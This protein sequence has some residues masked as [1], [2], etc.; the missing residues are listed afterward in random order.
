MKICH[1]FLL[2]FSLFFSSLFA[3]EVLWNGNLTSVRHT[4]GKHSPQFTV[5]NGTLNIKASMDIPAGKHEYFAFSIDVPAFSLQEK[6][7]SFNFA[8]RN[9]DSRDM[10][11]IKAM[12]SSGKVVGSFYFR[13]NSPVSRAFVCTAGRDA[14]GVTWFAS[15]VKAPLTDP[16]VKLAFFYCRHDG[17][18]TLDLSLSEV[19]TIPPPPETLWNGQASSVRSSTPKYSPQISADGNMINIK[20]AFDTQKSEYFVFDVDVTDFIMQGKALSFQFSCRQPLRGDMFYIK[21]LNASGQVVASF[22]TRLT[23]DR[24]RTYICSPESNSGGVTWFASDIKAPLTDKV[25]KLRFFYCRMAGK[26]DLEIN[27]GN[28]EL[29][30]PAPPVATVTPQDHGRAV[31]GGTC[32]GLHTARDADG[33]DC[34][35]VFLMDDI[36]RRMLQIDAATGESEEIPI[37]FAPRDAVYSSLKSRNG[38][39]YSLFAH[40]FVEY[41]PAQK[42][43]TFVRKVKDLTAMSMAEDANGIIYA[44]TYPDLCLYSYDP[45][46]G[47]FRDFGQIHQETFPQYPRTITFA[48]D[49]TLY[50]GTGNTR[51]Q[52]IHVYPSSGRAVPVIPK[53]EEPA[54][55]SLFVRRFTDGKIYARHNDL[56]FLIDGDTATRLDHVPDARFITSPLT[57]SQ[58]LVIR[59]F[60]S[61]RKLVTFDLANG[62]LVTT[63]ADGS[64]V[65]AVD[66]SF[67]NHGAPMMGID[68]TADGIVGGGGFFPFFFGTFDPATNEKTVQFADVQ[69]NAIQAH[70]KYFYIAGYAGGLIMRFDPS[71]PWTLTTPMQRKEADLQ[72]NPVFYG[73]A[74]QV[75][76]RPHA[77]SVSPDGKIFVAG[78]TPEYGHTGGGMAIVDTQSGSMTL[79]P[80]TDLAPLESPHALA[81]L[82]NG[83]VICGTTVNA[84]TGGEIK[85]AEASL[86]IYD[87][88]RNKPSGAVRNW[89]GSIPFTSLFCWMITG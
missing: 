65:R 75:T 38:K 74:R 36:N 58:N 41:D 48:D 45:A 15:D 67:V 78:G 14:G 42:K 16:V 62:K 71:K 22:Y 60:D 61:G 85:A 70:G 82:D 68:V 51:G 64:E 72:S 3:G 21:A 46:T 31:R 76:I 10:F 54:G 88:H 2:V 39:C 28:F 13:I 79:V 55:K 66:F 86:L 77:I 32:R 50:V 43:F 24:Q 89:A 57:G 4:A 47:E 52:V 27:I 83:L 20:A 26:N 34:V 81:V 7:I 80:H 35:V 23:D 1:L 8:A 56:F 18:N 25:V 11:Y 53:A 30:D 6:S 33:N 87:I 73:T 5:D 49:G 63:N 9:T 17:N 37:P 59:D 69:C 19:Q 12:N 44:A 40:H 84:G 29:V